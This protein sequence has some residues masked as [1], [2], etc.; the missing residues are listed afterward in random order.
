MSS[1]PSSSSEESVPQQQQQQQSQD[2]PSAAGSSKKYK[3]ADGTLYSSENNDLPA[4]FWEDAI[5]DDPNHP[6]LVAM[7]EIMYGESTP[8][9]RAE[10][11]KIQG[12]EAFK[13]GPGNHYYFREAIKCYTQALSVPELTHE[14]DALKATCLSN[15]AECH[16]RLG[17]NGHALSDAQ[18]ACILQPNDAPKAYLRAAKAARALEK[19]EKAAV[20]ARCGAEKCRA[21]KQDAFADQLDAIAQKSDE[22]FTRHKYRKELSEAASSERGSG[23]KMLAQTALAKGVDVGPFAYEM[24]EGCQPAFAID[25]DAGVDDEGLPRLAWP[26]LLLYGES[27]QKD[28]LSSVPETAVISDLLDEVFAAPPDWDDACVYLRERVEVY[29]ETSLHPARDR[30]DL[31]GVTAEITKRALEPYGHLDPPAGSSSGELSSG[32]FVLIDE[33]LT[34]GEVVKLPGHVVPGVLVLHVCARGTGFREHMLSGAFRSA[35]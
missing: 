16:L 34:I 20:V 26:T 29:Y 12:N 22:E 27:M 31:D 11:F 6:D 19:F 14:D 2:E 30:L 23:A 24:P 35:S 33:S 15:R 18:A 25:D 13:F 4:L 32:S 7:Q 3:G 17:N 1:S 9:E 5:P 21:A 8:S 28:V 10:A